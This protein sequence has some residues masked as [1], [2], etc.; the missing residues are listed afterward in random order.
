MEIKQETK[1][2]PEWGL[3]SMVSVPLSKPQLRERDS[4]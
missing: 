3:S 4:E 2:K 1:D